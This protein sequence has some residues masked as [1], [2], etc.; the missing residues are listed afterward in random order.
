[1][2]RGA[3]ARCD[4]VPGVLVARRLRPWQRGWALLVRQHWAPLGARLS[5]VFGVGSDGGG[6]RGGGHVCGMVFA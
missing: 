2:L 5:F 1:M 3:G 6:V 4:G